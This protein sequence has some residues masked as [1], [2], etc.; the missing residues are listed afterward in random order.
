MY[1][2]EKREKLLRQGA[3]AEDIHIKK[4]NV[5]TLVL[6]RPPPHKKTN[7]TGIGKVAGLA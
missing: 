7:S 2:I 5:V 6:G 3:Q 4:G 1:E